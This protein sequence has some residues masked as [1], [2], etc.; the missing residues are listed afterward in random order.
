M[1]RSGLLL[2]VGTLLPAL[3]IAQVDTTDHAHGAYYLEALGPG[4]LGSMN[5]ERQVYRWEGSSLAVRLGLGSIQFSNYTGRFDP[6]VI[7][8]VGLIL[9]G[10]RRWSPEVGA[11]L[12]FTSITYPDPIDYAPSRR[13]ATYLWLSAGVRMAPQRD[14]SGWTLRLAYTPIIDTDGWEHW[15]GVSIGRTF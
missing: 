7:L 12:A 6:D 3:A 2:A 5:F 14:R 1:V 15:G 9:A 11:G 13:G 10:A 4:G 8:P